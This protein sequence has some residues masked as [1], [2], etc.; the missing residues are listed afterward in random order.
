[1][2]EELLRCVSF[3]DLVSKLINLVIAT[4]KLKRPGNPSV[5]C[6]L[7]FSN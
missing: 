5:C 4:A 7:E 2:R 6:A 1:M 3:S